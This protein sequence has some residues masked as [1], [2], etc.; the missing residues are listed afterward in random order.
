MLDHDLAVLRSKLVER[1]EILRQ[2]RQL[3]S[4]VKVIDEH[5]GAIRRDRDLYFRRD[6]RILGLR[7]LGQRNAYDLSLPRFKNHF[8]GEVFVTGL[9]HSDFVFSRQQ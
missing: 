8:S 4:L 6:F 9:P 5:R 3:D 2:R 1:G 7:I